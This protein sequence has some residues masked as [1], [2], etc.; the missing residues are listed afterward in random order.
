[1][2][3]WPLAGAVDWLPLATVLGTKWPGDDVRWVSCRWETHDAVDVAEPELRALAVAVAACFDAQAAAYETAGGSDLRRLTVGLDDLAV[4]DQL[5]MLDLH[6]TW[7]VRRLQALAGN[8]IADPPPL[9][10]RDLAELDE[11]AET[12]YYV[13]RSRVERHEPSGV[14]LRLVWCDGH[15]QSPS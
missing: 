12:E 6:W 11:L 9:S 1:M 7:T 14:E 5:R 8:V 4:A 3:G 15:G 13:R 10:P 2:P